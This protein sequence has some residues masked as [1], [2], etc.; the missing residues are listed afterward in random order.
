M[1][2]FSDD[3]LSSIAQQFHDLSATIGQFRLDE[4]RR[5]AK[6]ADPDIVRLL[7]LQLSLA[8]TSSALYL[9]AALVILADADQVATRVTASTH[10]ANAA[11]KTLQLVNKVISI[12]SAAGVLAT[13]VITG[14]MGQIES[15][16]DGIHAAIVG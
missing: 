13:A 10:E 12:G 11:M 15:A 8:N 7:G 6:L 14:D 1:P 9:Q 2:H 5:G 16:A 4:I 3:Q